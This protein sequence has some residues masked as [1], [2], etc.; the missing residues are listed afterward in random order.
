VALPSAARRARLLAVAAAG[1]A[2]WGWRTS[3]LKHDD[4]VCTT[5][6]SAF[7]AG[8]RLAGTPETYSPSAVFAAEDRAA[9]C[10]TDNLIFIKPP[11]YAVLMWPLA[12]LPFPAAL[13]LWRILGV[14]A[15]GMFVWLWPGDKFA[16]LAGCAWFLPVATSI[17]TGQDVAF[18]LAAVAGA[19]RLLR[20][21][22]MFA[23]GLIFGLCAIKFHLLLLLPLLILHRRW[24][25]AGLGV[26]TTGAVFAAISF[27]AYGWGWPALYRRALADPRL[28]PYPWNMVN[29][30]GLFRYHYGWVIPGALLVALLCWYLI[31]AGKLELALAAILAG[32]TLIA[33]HNT[34]S[35]G[36][37]FL[38]LLFGSMESHH[39]LARATAIF[40][41]TPFYAFLP[42]GALQVIVVILLATAAYGVSAKRSS[43][44]PQDAAPRNA[45]PA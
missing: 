10:H 7:Y 41:L 3:L 24:W 8:G 40:A 9:G 16:R 45:A 28:N 34:I 30:T 23:A 35:D 22:Q 11:F 2:F 6:F 15:L 5:D 42:N 21:Q 31:A 29:L 43:A 20:R 1:I 13:L 19:A 37:L 36:V 32:G 38:P 26:L 39:A 33:P 4:R 12:Q 18:V 25:R 27:A 17:N 44:A 14:A